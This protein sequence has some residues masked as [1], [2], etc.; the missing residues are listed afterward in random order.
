VSKL[1]GE[2]QRWNQ[3]V[4]SRRKHL[5]CW[6]SRMRYYFSIVSEPLQCC[7]QGIDRKHPEWEAKKAE[8]LDYCL[9]QQCKSL[10]TLSGQKG[11]YA[12][13]SDFSYTLLWK[14]SLMWHK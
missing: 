3:Q 13:F 10:T 14:V 5:H 2:H 1:D 12:D 7:P 4:K 9:S 8:I 6:V 11:R